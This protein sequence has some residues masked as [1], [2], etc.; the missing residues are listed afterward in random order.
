VVERLITVTAPAGLHARPAAEFVRLASE[1]A[2]RVRVRA[3]DRGP[4]D[5]ASILGIMT[6]GV[7]RG[8]SI[9]VSVD[10]PDAEAVLDRLALILDPAR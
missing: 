8:E 4:I 6:L 1:Y 3:A 7:E 5:G 10:G 2:G 9:V